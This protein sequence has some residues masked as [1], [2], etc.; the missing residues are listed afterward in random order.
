MARSINNSS[1]LFTFENFF[2]EIPMRPAI[3]FAF[4]TLCT[5]VTFAVVSAAEPTSG[6]FTDPQ[7]AGIDFELQGEYIGEHKSDE[8]TRKIGIQVI[9]LGNNTYCA[10]AYVGGLPGDGWSRGD[11]RHFGNGELK[12][13]EVQFQ[14]DDPDSTDGA[15]ATLKD[16]KITIAHNGKTV[17]ELKKVE[18]KS[19]T[20]GA[21]PPKGAIVLFDGSTIDAWE[22]G[23]IV[24]KNLLASTNPSSR[25]KLGDHQLHIEFRTPFMPCAGPGPG[26]QRCLYPEPLRMPGARLIWVGR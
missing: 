13:G 16:G 4:I 9:A 6:T 8:G 11:E 14:P 15:I 21:R 7:K 10:V 24:E 18:R 19:L 12:N 17:A 26:Q 2:S 3:S 23:N 1:Q 20:L 25:Q 22:N 5:V